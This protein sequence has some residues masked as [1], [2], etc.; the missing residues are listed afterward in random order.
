MTKQ[1]VTRQA[2]NGQ[3]VLGLPVLSSAHPDSGTTENGSPL[4]LPSFAHSLPSPIPTPF[5]DPSLMEPGICKQLRHTYT[6]SIPQKIN[7]QQLTPGCTVT[8]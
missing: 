4:G 8:K 7:L 3:L 1:Q 2:F 5:S 6:Q